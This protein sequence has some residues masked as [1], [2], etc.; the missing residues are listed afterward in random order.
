MM[1]ITAAQLCEPGYAE[2]MSEQTGDCTVQFDDNR[3]VVMPIRL[4]LMNGMLWTVYRAFDVPIVPEK[5]FWLDSICDETPIDCGTVMYREL[6]LKLKQPHLEVLSKVWIMMNRI[7]RFIHRKCRAYQVSLS[8]LM[9]DRMCMQ[10]PMKEVCTREMDESLGT[11]V[12]EAVFAQ[13]T[14]DLYSVLQTPGKLAYN[15]L[16]P[17][18][19][20]K[21]LKRNQLP[22]MFCAYGPR[23]DITDEM[24]KHIINANAFSGLVDVRDFATEYLS[25]KKAQFNNT[26]TIRKA[27]YF[28]R[29]LRLSASKIP[30]IYPGWCGSD[31][32]LKFFID[33]KHKMNFIGKYIKVTPEEFKKYDTEGIHLYDDCSIA[34]TKQN[35]DHFAGKVVSMWSP[36]CC[37]HTDGICEHCI[38]YM[39]QHAIAFLP[40]DIQLGVYCATKLGSVVTQR[41]LSSKH[42]IKTNSKEYILGQDVL[43]YFSKNNDTLIIQASAIP[44]LRKSYLR[45][46]VSDIGP[47]SDLSHS[48]LPSGEAWSTINQAQVVTDEGNVIDTLCMTDW[49]TFPYFSNYAMSYMKQHYKELRIGGEFV[50]IPMKDFDF[51]KPMFK[52]TAVNDD[53]VTY[54]TNVDQFLCAKICDYR[55]VPKCLTD[56]S[57]LVY[58]KADISIFYIELMLR[59]F[60]VDRSGANFSVPIITDTDQPVEFDRMSSTISEAS[61][62]T[63]L[64][65]ERLKELFEH[66]EPT[67]YSRGNGYGLN[68]AHFNFKTKKRV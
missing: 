22:Q 46:L 58:S 31:A 2:R 30:K 13:I 39:N 20:T 25:A 14:K 42:L 64:S 63:K 41:I 33:P 15:P 54:V 5:I 3:E 67:L 28:A 40:P 8:A 6:V 37:K 4:A 56:F 55:S 45:I 36:F 26:G 7:F 17:F 61:V 51:H 60:L 52:F 24:M 32:T 53:M 19:K 59:A 65:F 18:M 34:L 43:R 38:G 27:Q 23:S 68:D 49:T 12:G 62:S 57:N 35:I 48:P 1:T 11:R 21:L 66:A 10:E 50:D 9:L 16:A 47:T 29:R 44:L